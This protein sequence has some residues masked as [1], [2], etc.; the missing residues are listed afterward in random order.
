[1]VAKAREGRLESDS[2]GFRGVDRDRVEDESWVGLPHRRPDE[3]SAGVDCDLTRE[4]IIPIRKVAVNGGRKNTFDLGCN[5]GT[6][7]VGVTASTS[8]FR[9][10]VSF[11]SKV[12]TFSTALW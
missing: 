2:L 9:A 8:L 6:V 3:V 12:P 1:M 4:G 10:A 11:S 7:P 5:R